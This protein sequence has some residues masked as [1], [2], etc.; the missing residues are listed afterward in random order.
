[1]K[2]VNQRT[3]GGQ[4]IYLGT[5]NFSQGAGIKVVL[6]DNADGIVVADAVRLVKEQ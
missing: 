1:M 5:W 2:T 4:W 3:G 6:S